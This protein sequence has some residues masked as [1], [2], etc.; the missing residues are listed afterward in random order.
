MSPPPYFLHK[1]MSA[2]M[3]DSDKIVASSV[4]ISAEE[5]SSSDCKVVCMD[6]SCRDSQEK[7]P[8][9]IGCPSLA[10]FN[11]QHK[12]TNGLCAASPER[13]NYLF[14]NRI[15]TDDSCS[16]FTDSE[17]NSFPQ[18]KCEDG[19][20]R[21]KCLDFYGCSLDLPFRCPDGTCA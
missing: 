11:I 3:L 13:C 8:A 15:K 18:K 1:P 14:G 5:D 20:C 7:C 10:F 4:D 12:C 16:E 19:V 2:Y 9:I 21:P 6:G 17:G